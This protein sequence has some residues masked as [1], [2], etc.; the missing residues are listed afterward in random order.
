MIGLSSGSWAQVVANHPQVEHLTSVEINPGYLQL[1]PQYP[2]VATLLQNPKAIIVIDDGRRWLVRNR[3][4]KFDLIVM[5][6]SFH[7]RAH[8]TNLLSRE[9]LELTRQHLNPGGILFYNTTGSP[10][11]QLTAATTFPYALRVLNFIAVSDS[12][13]KIDK[14]RWRQVLLAYRIDNKPVL[15]MTRIKDRARLAD[16][17]AMPDRAMTGGADAPMEFGDTIRRRYGGKRIVTD[18]NMGTEWMQ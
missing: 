16:V 15:D 11:V 1:I 10:E 14:E 4:R 7:W 13:I 2:D 6:T 12:P 18:D 5:N 8:A 3:N 9:F 17:L